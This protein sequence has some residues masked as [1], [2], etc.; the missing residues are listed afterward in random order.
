MLPRLAIRPI[1]LSATPFSKLELIGGTEELLGPRQS[2]RTAPHVSIVIDLLEWD[3]GAS[4]SVS[5]LPERQNERSQRPFGAT[6]GA[7]IDVCPAVSVL[8]WVAGRRYNE[9]SVNIKV[10]SSISTPSLQELA[11][12]IP[13]P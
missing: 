1:D 3:M 12:S 13:G 10:R 8:I 5:M 11:E 4:G 6:G 2:F 7:A 9:L